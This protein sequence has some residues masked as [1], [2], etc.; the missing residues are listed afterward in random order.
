M[1]YR[2]LFYVSSA[3]YSMRDGQL[4]EL[5]EESLKNNERFGVTGVLMYVD[6]VFLQVIEG[7]SAAID[8]LFGN[9]RSDCRNSAVTKTLD[10]VVDR[11]A[12]PRWSMGFR[13]TGSC[14][15][16]YGQSFHNI[17][18][19][20]DLDAIECSDESVLSLVQGLFLS[21]AGRSF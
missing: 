2:Q 14:D 15:K 1:E 5:R 19:R 16:D 21:N 11:P 17:K 8:Q 13:S 18:S 9:I 6:R 7:R 4:H 12:F 3:T 20:E 10:R